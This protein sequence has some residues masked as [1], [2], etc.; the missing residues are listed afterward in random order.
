[1]T[2]TDL[3]LGAL[4]FLPGVVLL[5]VL[6]AWLHRRARRTEREPPKDG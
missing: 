1:M 6:I 3:L 4:T 5:S 2:W